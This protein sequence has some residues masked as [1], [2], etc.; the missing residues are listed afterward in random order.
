VTAIVCFNWNMGAVFL[1]DS[2]LS[3][4]A[5]N[6][7]IVTVRDVCQKLFVPNGWCTF[8]FAGNLCLANAVAAAFATKLNHQKW[9]RAHLLTNDEAMHDIAISSIATHPDDFGEGHVKCLE[10]GAALLFAYTSLVAHNRADGTFDHHELGIF[11]TSVN[12][13][14]AIGRFKS[15]LGA[16]V[17]GDG[18]EAIQH[19]LTLDVMAQV[20]NGGTA[21]LSTF[22]ALLVATKL[23]NEYKTK[24][25]GLPFQA[26][27]MTPQG[28]EV[29]PYF[30]W[31]DI[32]N[33][34]GTYVALRI[35]NGDWVQ[36][37]RPTKVKRRIKRPF[38]ILNQELDEGAWPW[39]KSEMF[40]P[41]MSLTSSAPGVIRKSQL[42]P[43][44]VRYEPKMELPKEILASWGQ[45]PIEMLSWS[46]PS[47]ATSEGT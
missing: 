39:T 34:F 28:V 38:E 10:E 29:M 20:A 37:H 13:A 1:A 7:N 26:V 33:R 2:R 17:L 32:T 30:Y 44:Y 42:H 27:Y 35:E 6:G 11:T 45:A 47:G 23:V 16:A 41:R 14:G 24:T 22:F 31:V 4:T 12:S 9:T 19:A 5:P 40:D 25:V 3:Y 43:V 8:G 15:G 36:E 46:T 21:E 18:A